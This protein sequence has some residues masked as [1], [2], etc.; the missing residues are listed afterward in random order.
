MSQGSGGAG[1]TIAATMYMKQALGNKPSRRR[2]RGLGS[3]V[4]WIVFLIGVLYFFV[5]LV[6]T[7]LFSLKPAAFGDAYVATAHDTE[8]FGS[9]LYSFVIA[10][11]TVIGSTLLIVPT[12]YWVRLKVPRAR[13][14]VEFITL[15]P[16]VVPPVILV[17]GLLNTY[18]HP[19]LFLTETN[20][21]ND[22]LM[23]CAYIVLSF[24]YMY[25]AVDTGLRA[26]DIRS[27]TEAGQSLGAGWFRILWSVI[28]PNLRVSI[29]AG[30]FL[31]V[32]IVVGEFTIAIF[33]GRKTFAPFLSILG[34]HDPYE[35][36]AV[37]LVSF[38]IT[39]LAMGLIGLVGRGSRARIQVAGAH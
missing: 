29:L 11:I 2:R 34:D 36:G 19:P 20:L 22:V 27:L 38:G 26:I 15:L 30:A 18:S 14:L 16:F 23:V 25:R 8:L 9:L 12:A 4:W 10:I 39:W 3:I 37:T 17:F 5:P 31:T 21:G 1:S 32:A 28:L 6:A 24:P 33:L 35:Q 7:L 13:P